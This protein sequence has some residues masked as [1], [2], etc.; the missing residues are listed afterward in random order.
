MYLYDEIG[1]W[2]VSAQQFVK[3]L[4]NVKS[5]TIHLRINSPGGSVFDGTS[6]YNALKQHPANVIVHVDGLAASIASIIALAGNEVR[7]SENAFFMI[8]EPWSMVIG[9]S[10]EMRK[11]AD[12]LDKVR[13]MI[14]GTYM[15]KS[16]K[17]EKEV[18]DL[19]AE[20]TWMSAEEALSMGFIDAIDSEGAEEVA[21]FDLSVFAKVPEKLQNIEVDDMTERELERILKDAGCS[22]RQAKTILAK[23]F[24]KEQRDVVP[25][26]PLS[27]QRDVVPVA[28]SIEAL[29]IQAE[30]IAPK[31]LKREV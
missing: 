17:P 9:S 1:Y 11:E 27:P 20:E 18:L 22:N 2:G 26:E 16:G 30:M 12:L 31:Q 21:L 7:M 5:K 10:E 4:E 19:M 6:M 3:D 15:K 23:G 24:Q 13:G 25:P 14:A 29:L 8:H 28:G